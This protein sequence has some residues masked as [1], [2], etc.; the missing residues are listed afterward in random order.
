MATGKSMLDG[1]EIMVLLL[2]WELGFLYG[3]VV[4]SKEENLMCLLAM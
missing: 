2:L 1:N 3:L 4:V